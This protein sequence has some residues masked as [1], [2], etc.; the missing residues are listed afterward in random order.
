MSRII[1]TAVLLLYFCIE[2]S[3]QQSI[4]SKNN[5]SFSPLH[6]FDNTFQ[7]GYERIF[8]GKTSGLFMSGGVTYKDE[9]YDYKA[10]GSFEVHYRYYLLNPSS[11][12]MFSEKV[13]FYAAP[14]IHSRY[15]E[16]IYNNWSWVED[17]SMPD[18]GYVE[19]RELKEIVKSIGLGVLMGLK[20]QIH[21]KIFV[22]SYV[23]GGLKIS[24][25][26][27]E[28]GKDQHLITSPGYSGVVPKG[29]I[30]IGIRF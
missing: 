19:E 27:N 5:L 13:V 2:S 21:E 4:E 9:N 22:E 24:D 17:L 30:S 28:G 7:L 26:D 3:A 15:L 25:V 23:G 6:L 12:S 8:I 11:E 20:L 18:N 10:G 1:F 16:T 14:Y 29:S